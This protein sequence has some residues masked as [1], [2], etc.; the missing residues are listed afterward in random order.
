MKTAAR[1]AAAAM[2]CRAAPP[3]ILAGLDSGNIAWR[4]M[5]DRAVPYAQWSLKVALRDSEKGKLISLSAGFACH[6]PPSL[7]ERGR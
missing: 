6:A 7:E 2:P 1:V 5:R 3:P 4:M